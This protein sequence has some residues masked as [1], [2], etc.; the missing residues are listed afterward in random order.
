MPGTLPILM[1]PRR[2]GDARGWF[3]ETF[4]ESS[5]ATAGIGARFV[6]DNQ[7]FSAGEGTLR[8]LHFQRPPHAQAKLVRC[9]R[10]SVMDY[11]VDLRRGSPTYGHYVS[12]KLTSE[13]GEQLYIPIGFAHGFVTL[14][15]D[16]EIAYKVSDVYAPECDGG[17]LWNDSTIGIEWPLPASGP[18]LSDKDAA[19]PTL[20]EFDCPFEYDGEPLMPLAAFGRSD[21]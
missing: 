3:M 2:I 5:A 13:G 21:L 15:S 12:A 18:I 14:E 4:S 17:I 1:K 16:V 19:L 11:A 9:V 10:G 8:G 20:A 7:S 6:Q